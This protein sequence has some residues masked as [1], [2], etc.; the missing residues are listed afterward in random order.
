MRRW[1]APP[2]TYPELPFASGVAM[3]KW[4]RHALALDERRAKFQPIYR[5][6]D[7]EEEGDKH[8]QSGKIK[9][10]VRHH[11]Q[12]GKI[13]QRVRHA[14]EALDAQGKFKAGTASHYSPKAD[15]EEDDFKNHIA[16]NQRGDKYLPRSKE[17]WFV[18]AHSDCGVGNDSNGMPSLSN[19]SFR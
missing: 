15:L 1:L 18:G 5:V 6:P 11:I 19:I 10:R 13:K 4:F 12:Y 3:V 16:L 14:N 8:I 7:P 2:P 9:Q 17:V